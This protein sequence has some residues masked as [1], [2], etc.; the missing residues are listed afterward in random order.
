[1]ALAD[2]GFDEAKDG[3]SQ[4][5]EAVGS[6]DMRLFKGHAHEQWMGLSKVLSESST[7]GG[8][9]KDI[10]GV[11]DAFYYVSKAI[12]DLEQV[13]GHAAEQDYFLTYCPMARDHTGAYWLQTVDT[14]YNSYYGASMLRCGAIKD[15]LAA[16]TTGQGN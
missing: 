5:A 7:A 3:S 13:F 14:V 9:S 16:A 15:T 1:M 6:V 12:I 8:S 10:A 2:D 11:R 4:L